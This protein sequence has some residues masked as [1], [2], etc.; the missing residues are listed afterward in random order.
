MVPL[1]PETLNPKPYTLPMTLNLEEAT[2]GALK[3]S[4]H[5]T[6]PCILFEVSLHGGVIRHAQHLYPTSIP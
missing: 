2:H 4:L 3:K 6:R 5:R 1:K